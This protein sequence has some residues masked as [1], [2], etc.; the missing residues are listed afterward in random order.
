MS[1]PSVK[2]L[3]HICVICHIQT[4]EVQSYQARPNKTLQEIDGTL[5]QSD[6]FSKMSDPFLRGGGGG[7]DNLFLEQGL[8]KGGKLV[9]GIS[10]ACVL[11]LSHA[12]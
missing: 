6:C 8:G 12:E 9:I 7:E 10:S 3:K 4:H 5:P 11:C 2:K 1:W